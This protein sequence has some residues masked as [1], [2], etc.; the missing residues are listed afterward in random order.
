MSIQSEPETMLAFESLLDALRAAGEPTRLRILALLADAT[1]T[2]SDLT[3]ILRQ[4]Q[5]RVS[6]HLKLL[7]DAGLIERTAE[8]A[9]AYFHL[10]SSDPRV[11]VAR[12]ALHSLAGADPTLASDRERLAAVRADR[13]TEAQRFFDQHAGEWD[14]IR[15]LHVG[16]ERVEQALLDTLDRRAYRSVLDIGTGTGRLLELLGRRIERGVG[17]DVSPRMLS[18]ARNKLDQ[19]GLRHCRIRQADLH[20]LGVP[21]NSFDVAIIHQVLHLLDDGAAAIREAAGTLTPGGRLIVVDFAP[22]TQERLRHDFAHRRL[23]FTPE[24]IE[25]WMAA[26]GLSPTT[27]ETLTPEPNTNGR[28]AISIWVGSDPRPTDPDP[29]TEPSS[30]PLDA[31]T[32]ATRETTPS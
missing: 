28:I 9:W 17:V 27:C 32:S 30:A 5:P 24:A 26:A 8:G 2:V 12:A 13:A 18:I 1:L 15:Q 4:A 7:T 21:P 20:A 22:H 25:T 29:T 19:A 6:R 16:D 23:G 3:E 10:A 11:Q 31:A 14:A